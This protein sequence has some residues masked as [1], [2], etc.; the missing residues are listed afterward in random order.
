MGGGDL[1][2]EDDNLFILLQKHP[3]LRYA[4]GYGF[5][6]CAQ[7]KKVS[8]SLGKRGAVTILL[9]WLVTDDDRYA[10]L[11][12]VTGLWKL[13]YEPINCKTI[14]QASVAEVTI[15]RFLLPVLTILQFMLV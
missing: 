7:K 8:F 13:S 15:M 4:I 5:G 1:L 9:D 12:I 6:S 11:G 10:Q 2:S 3:R 14:I